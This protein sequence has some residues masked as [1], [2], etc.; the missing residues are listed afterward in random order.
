MEIHPQFRKKPPLWRQFEDASLEEREKMVD[1]HEEWQS[2]DGKDIAVRFGGKIRLHGFG[3]K[4]S[5]DVFNMLESVKWVKKI[6]HTG[7]WIRLRNSFTNCKE[8]DRFRLQWLE[9]HP[10]CVRC[11]RTYNNG[12]QVHHAG[13]FNQDNVVMEE[14]FLKGLDHPERFETLCATCHSTLHKGMISIES[15]VKEKNIDV[16]PQK[17]TIRKKVATEN[18][19]SVVISLVNPCLN[20]VKEH[21]L[22]KVTETD[23]EDFL[24][25]RDLILSPRTE[26]RLLRALVSSFI[27]QDKDY[28]LTGVP[29]ADINE[30]LSKMDEHIPINT[31]K[32]SK[33]GSLQ[34]L[35]DPCVDW[36]HERGLKKVTEANIDTFLLERD[37]D[38]SPRTERRLLQ[39]TVN[40]IINSK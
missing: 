37:T 6:T 31:K 22:K 27:R 26:R 38:L 14:G 21:G 16:L 39:S 10:I 24:V 20:W 13:Y 11:G 33:L 3:G 19:K 29:D 25:D 23:I 28:D 9:T 34:S 18:K 2:P 1:W 35:V 5:T 17:R 8:W 15:N 4:R 12:L 32:G 7:K 36:A 30:F 40:S